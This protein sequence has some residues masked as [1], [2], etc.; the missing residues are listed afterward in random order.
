MD[1]DQ[2]EILQKT[3]PEARGLVVSMITAAL[4]AQVDGDEDLFGEVLAELGK[5]QRVTI[6]A[7][8]MTQTWTLVNAIMAMA[9]VAETDPREYWAEVALKLT[10]FQMKEDGEAEGD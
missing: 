1:D 7:V 4:A 6:R 5:V 9:A 8:L 10:A 3:F 2:K